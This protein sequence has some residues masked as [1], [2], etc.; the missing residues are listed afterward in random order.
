M[1]MLHTIIERLNS[2]LLPS[3]IF[4]S[5]YGLCE[6]RV[7]GGEREWVYY[8]GGGQATPVTNYDTK[9][10]TLFWHKRGRVSVSKSE[11]RVSGCKQIYTTTFPL[12]AYVVVKKKHI[13]CD[14]AY[15]QDWVANEVFKYISGADT[16]LKEQLHL[17][18]FDTIPNGYVNEIKSLPANYEYASLIIDFDIEIKSSSIN[19][20]NDVCI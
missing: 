12:S 11:L 8:T 4:D 9:N 17:I 10:G 6:L 13:P 2:K 20:C 14:S 19:L 18:S 3:N 15:A 16:E 7:K 5:I 1:T